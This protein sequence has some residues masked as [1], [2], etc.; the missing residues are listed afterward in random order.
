MPSTLDLN[1][2]M[3]TLAADTVYTYYQITDT[4]LTHNGV[5]VMAAGS[6]LRFDNKAGDRKSV[7]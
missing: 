2:G 4:S 5:L 6:I 7:V 1:A 3:I